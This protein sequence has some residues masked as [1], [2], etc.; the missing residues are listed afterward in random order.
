MVDSEPRYEFRYLK[1]YLERDETIDLNVVLLS[2]DPNYSDAG[3]IGDSDVSGSEGRLVRVRRRDLRRRRRQ[4]PEPVAVAE[5]GRVRHREGRR[6]ALRRR[7][8]FQPARL[9]RH[10]A[11]AAAADRAVGCAKPDRGWNDGDVVPP[12]ADPGRTGQPDLP[13]R[14]RRRLE[15]GRSGNGLP[16]LFWYFEAPRKK[17]AAL[18]LAEHRYRDGLRRQAPPGSLPVRGRRQVDVP[19]L[20]RYMALALPRGRQ[21]LRTVLGPD[22]PLSGK[23]T[24][25]LASVRP[26]SRPTAADISAA[27]RSSFASGFRTPGSRPRRATSRSRSAVPDRAC[28][29]S[30]SSW[31]PAP[32]TSSKGPCRRPLKETT[33]CGC[34][35]PRYSKVRFRPPPSG[36]MHPSM[37]LSAS[38]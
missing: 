34:C 8:S 12:G 22:D 36:L 13:V 3:S 2:S 5:P 29:S 25:G 10:A 32:T 37:S 14:R 4:L 38:K 17:P 16:E 28:A 6:S 27:S 24:T 9:P 21:V 26:R 35:R 31:C 30:R 1:N 7:R 18:V 23:V 20:R 15:H 11:R 33:K 19:R